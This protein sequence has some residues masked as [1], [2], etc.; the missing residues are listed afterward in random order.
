LDEIYEGML[1]S[2]DSREEARQILS[3][4]CYASEP[5]SVHEVAEALRFTGGADDILHVCPGLVEFSLDADGVQRAR[6]GHFSVQEY[7]LSD[8]IRFGRAAYFALSGPSQHGWIGKAG[9]MQDSGYSTMTLQNATSNAPNSKE[10]DDVASVLSVTESVIAARSLAPYTKAALVDSFA[11]LLTSELITCLE[12][13][14]DD[15]G[16][17]LGMMPTLLS[18]FSAELK[19]ETS[20]DD[21]LL[22]RSTAAFV[23]FYRS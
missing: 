2:I 5:L 19:A 21:V 23:H 13:S 12:G 10:A 1:C 22:R 17:L 9:S 15:V 14:H 20:H 4:L 11:A 18:K 6:I 3:L 16:L 7:L 8:R